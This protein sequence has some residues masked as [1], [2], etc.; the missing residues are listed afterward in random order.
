MEIYNF[1]QRS[2][3]WYEI[4][5]GLMTASKSSTIAT[6]GT[7]LYTYILEIMAEYYSTAPKEMYF[8]DDMKRGV[9]LE[10]EARLV[11]EL[12]NK[13][14]VEQV[15]FVVYNEYFGCSPDGLVESDGLV[16]FKAPNDKNYLELLL[17][18]KIKSEYIGQMQGQMLGTSRK[19]CDFVAYNPNFDQNIWIKRIYKDDTYQEKL[20]AGINK[21]GNLIEE[22]KSK[23]KPKQLQKLL[24]F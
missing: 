10:P 5:K 8:N 3:E 4:R 24:Q 11:Y 6:A 21:G 17:Y 2:P 23:L 16:E 19:W 20:K 1:E 12:E 13:V 15:G 9:E 14:T 18:E 22:I 7:G